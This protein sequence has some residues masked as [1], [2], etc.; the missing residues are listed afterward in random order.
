MKLHDLRH[1]IKKGPQTPGRP[2]VQHHTPPHPWL[3]V[4]HQKDPSLP[5]RQMAGRC[6]GWGFRPLGSS[7]VVV[8]DT[9]AFGGQLHVDWL[10]LAPVRAEVTSTVLE[11]LQVLDGVYPTGSGHS[12]HTKWQWH[13]YIDTY[14]HSYSIDSTYLTELCCCQSE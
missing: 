11:L 12:P 2:P 1:F 14:T 7:A 3:A 10:S 6:C 13:L 5:V 9:R 4:L 8:P